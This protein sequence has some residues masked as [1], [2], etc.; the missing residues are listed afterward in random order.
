VAEAYTEA[1]VRK[2]KAL[3]VGTRSTKGCRSVRSSMSGMVMTSAN[4]LFVNGRSEIR[5]VA[6]LIEAARAN[7]GKLSDGSLGM[8]ALPG[9][10]SL[11]PR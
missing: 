3:I 9:R 4:L 6:G 10:P 8:T 7:P 1:L 2:A 5:D 11:L